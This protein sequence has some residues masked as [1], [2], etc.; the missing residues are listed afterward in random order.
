MLGLA[1]YFLT[2][3]ALLALAIATR[4]ARETTHPPR[5]T[6]AW[7]VA[8]DLPI[9]PADLDLP[10]RAW[11]HRCS[12]GALL[13]V[14]TIDLQ[15]D[16]P[17]FPEL[18][19]IILHGWGR[20]RIDSLSRLRPW[21]GLAGAAVLYDLRGHGECAACAS[22]LG[23]REDADLIEILAEA[24]DGPFFLVG[25]SMGAGVA[26]TLAASEKA[27]PSLVGV[28][29]YG[30]YADVHVPMRNRLALKGWPSRPFTDLAL[31]VLRAWGVRP[32]RA[33]AWAGQVQRSVLIIQGRNDAVSPP[34]GAQRIAAQ[35]GA[36]LGWIDGGAHEDTHLVDPDAHDKTVREFARSVMK[37][38]ELSEVDAVTASSREAPAG[39]SGPRSRSEP[40]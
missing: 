38:V 20:S 25:H 4:I 30:P 6:A 34:E 22:R 21:R 13:P 3:A 9:D 18:T 28:V 33:A 14:W 24:C 32:P 12:D 26:L 2:C 16:S 40:S 10:F 29:A 37:S 1:A 35:V 31:L 36:R 7:A 8:H 5:R 17:A 27:P 23:D 39:R 11:T 15:A 19:V